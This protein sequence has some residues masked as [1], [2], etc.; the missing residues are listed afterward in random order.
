MN[1]DIQTIYTA[2]VFVLGLVGILLLWAW[3]QDRRSKA[4]V[5]WA[6][7]FFVSTVGVVLLSDYGFLPDVWTV[8]VAITFLITGHGLVWA[9]VRSFDDRPVP[10]LG[11]L[12]GGVVWSLA[13][14]TRLIETSVTDRIALIALIA[15]LYTAVTAWEMF[16]DGLVRLRSGPL[17][18]VLLTVHAACHIL[19]IP[20][21]EN[22]PYAF[23]PSADGIKV[24]LL[25]LEPMLFAVALGYLFLLMTRERGEAEIATLAMT[26]VLTGSL[27]RRGFF[28][29]AEGIRLAAQKQNKPIAKLLLDVDHFKEVNDTYGHAAGDEVLQSFTVLVRG[30]LRVDDVLGRIGGEEFAVMAV[31]ADAEVAHALAER[32]R[33]TVSESPI[34]WRE[35]PID[36]SVSIGVVVD[37]TAQ[38]PLDDLL[39][40]ADRALYEAKRHGRNKVVLADETSDGPE[41]PSRGSRA[42]AR[43]RRKKS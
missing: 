26:D 37:P 30:A 14:Q 12:A 6:L 43:S 5:W 31:D 40:V 17:V 39:E 11:I 41:K 1:I 20:V 18:L 35:T 7:S 28:D 36:V 38:R 15:A 42:R 3:L 24:A 25:A 2:L 10:W 23:E 4:L 21:A 19:R 34:M 33:A 32:I 9:G 8:D 16:R 22:F 13:Y 27:N 29:A